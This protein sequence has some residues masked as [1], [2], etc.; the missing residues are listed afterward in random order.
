[1]IENCVV[2]NMTGSGLVFV[3]KTPDMTTQLSVSNSYFTDNRHHGIYI[4]T[5]TTGGVT[6]SI[7]WVGICHNSEA[8]LFVDGNLAKGALVVAVTDSVAANNRVKGFLVESSGAVS[9]LVLTR[10]TSASN[11]TGIQALGNNASVWLAQSTV[12]GNATG[13]TFAAGGVIWSF[14]DNHMSD[15]AFNSGVLAISPLQ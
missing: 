5:T 1:V 13:F 3:A 10:S 2:R 11:N 15:N 9:K 6:A 7:D 8:G 14:R 4:G 12:T